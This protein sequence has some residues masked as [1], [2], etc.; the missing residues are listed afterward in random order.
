VLQLIKTWQTMHRSFLFLIL[1][2]FCH[3]PLEARL[4]DDEIDSDLWVIQQLSKM[5]LSQKVGQLFVVPAYATEEESLETLEALVVKEK[6]GGIIWMQGS[7]VRQVEWINH[8]QLMSKFPLLMAQDLEWGLAM[9]LTGTMRFPRHMT[10]GA[11]QDDLLVEEVAREIGRQARLIG[12]HLVLAPVVDIHTNPMNPV[13]LSR[14]FGAEK[15]S[16]ARK[17]VAFLRGLRRAG[18]LAC[19]KHFPGHG[20]T[21]IDSHNSLPTLSLT[22]MELEER[23]LYPFRELIR[24]KVPTVMVGHL[25][26]PE[27]TGG[28]EWPATLC[29]EV[30]EG[31][32]RQ[33]LGFDGVVITDALDMKAVQQ[34]WLPGELEIEALLAG[35]DLLLMSENPSAAIRAI[36]AAVESGEIEEERINQSVR[37]IL[38]LKSLVGLHTKSTIDFL[39]LRDLRTVEARKLKARAYAEAVTIVADPHELLPIRS[40]ALVVQVGSDSELPFTT[41]M[42]LPWTSVDHPEAS[43]ISQA[44]TILIALVDRNRAIEAADWA[45]ELQEQGKRIVVVL[46]TSP[47]AIE[48]FGEEESLIVAYEDDP[49]AQRATADLL[50]GRRESLGQLP[51]L[52]LSNN[53]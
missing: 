29:W 47:Y 48:A 13:T 50:R 8:L 38:K 41:R 28:E 4:V 5:D 18:V 33:D 11:I 49:E 35:N 1:I 19:A 14:S 26:L 10:L 7:P 20:D 21:Q 39:R 15:I 45:T 6:V 23:E 51:V 12:I 42:G 36:I 9:R 31:L 2:L 46:F 37:R 30:I 27:L 52:K 34:D 44:G 22:P 25:A 16:V 43:L 17:G 24:E 53:L 40:P 3:S 32:L